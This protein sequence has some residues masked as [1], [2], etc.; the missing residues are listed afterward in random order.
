MKTLKRFLYTFW[1]KKNPKIIN[2]SKYYLT[3]TKMGRV[4]AA[5]N[6]VAELMERLAKCH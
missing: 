5:V 1:I 2:G 6:S 4:G 3:K